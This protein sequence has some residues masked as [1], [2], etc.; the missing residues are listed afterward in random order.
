M[1]QDF[2]SLIFHAQNRRRYAHVKIGFGSRV[3]ES[4]FEGIKIEVGKDC[5]ILRSS[6]G[7]G[8][9]VKDGCAIFDS[10]F[11]KHTAVYPHCTLAHVKFGGYSYV[12]ENSAMGNVT[13]G[14]F[15]SIGPGFICGY[16][17][18]PTNFITTSPVFYSTRKQCGISFTETSRYDEQ[19]PTT[20]GNDVWIGARS[21][22][23]DGVKIGDGALIAAGAVVTADVPD[24]A[25]VG[26]VPAKLIRYR[27]PEDVV[28]QLLEIQW[29][30]WSEDRLRAAQPQLA[31]PDVNS[32]LEWAKANGAELN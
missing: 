7:E 28:Q 6:F 12:N 30:N 5:Y 9:F 32:F 1:I 19:Q 16:G 24:Y 14:R 17:E 27:F 15:T 29:W 21:F 25:I 23:R 8:A 26:G 4:R 31:Q 3:V 20:I 22:V 11:D 2:K 18:H 10:S 13:L